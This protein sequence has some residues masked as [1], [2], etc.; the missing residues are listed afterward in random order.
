MAKIPLALL[1]LAFAALWTSACSGFD[2]L[3][4]VQVPDPKPIGLGAL[5]WHLPRG[6]SLADSVLTVV[7]TSAMMSVMAE[8]SVDV[9]ALRGRNI[10]LSA[11]V[12]G[13]GLGVPRLGYHGLKLMIR[14]VETNGVTHWSGNQHLPGSWMRRIETSCQVPEASQCHATLMLGLQRCEGRVKFDLKT[15]QLLAVGEVLPRV[16][17]DYV[18]RYPDSVKGRGVKRGVMLP[19]DLEAIKED[20]FATLGRWGANLVRYQIAKN[21][22]ELNAWL[23]ADEYDKYL[24][25]ALDILE[26]RVLPLA[27]KYGLLVCIDLH[28]TPGA[29]CLQKENRMF[30]EDRYYRQFVETWRRIAVR[31]RDDPRL[32][33]YDL[34]NEPEQKHIARHSY[35]HCQLAAARAIREVDRVTPIIVSAPGF[36]SPAGFKDLSP[37]R[38]D[39]VIYQTHCYLPLEFTHQGVGGDM[40]EGLVTYP[41]P[42]RGWDREYVRRSLQPVLEFSRRHNAKI[43]IGEFSAVGWAPGADAYIRD[44]IAI[45][46]EYGWDWC[47]HAFREWDGWSVEHSWDAGTRRMLP[48][49]GNPRMEALVNGFKKK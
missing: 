7:S 23:D 22:N 21:W 44:C 1:G 13:E 39:N 46:N 37:I 16:N 42:E 19:A 8:A 31:F 26:S 5:D 3:D 47:Y 15:L 10:S 25:S 12:H 9:S 20:D 38:M 43:Y 45:F 28:A 4:D 11:E 18:V 41:N 33:G 17:G 32:Y 40:R 35:L 49:D 36:G 6:A 27:G 24:D 29:R 14:T 2:E 48:S 34:V 30:Y